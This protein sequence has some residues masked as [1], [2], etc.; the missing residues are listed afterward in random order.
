MRVT[1]AIITAASPSQARLPLQTVVDRTGSSRTALQLLLED[2]AQAG[3]EDVAVIVCPDQADRFSQAAGGLAE[4]LTFIE[5]GQPRGYGDALLRAREFAGTDP[6]LHL[7]GD[8]LYVSHTGKSCAAQLLEIAEREQ[9]SVSAVQATRENQL[10]YFGAV[11]GSPVPRRT[12]LFEVNSVLEKPTPTVAEQQLIV[13]GQRAGYYLCLFG[14][15]VLTSNVFELLAEEVDRLEVGQTANL[16]S[17]LHKLAQSQRYLAAE[18]EGE[19]YNI[20]QK[21]GLLIAQLAIALAGDEREL[22]LSELLELVAR[23]NPI[24]A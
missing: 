19:R 2:V 18:L 13:A 22:I 3:I 9:C 11:G 10:H 6:V 7:V 16:S 21:Y 17:S 20:G 15:H 24:H 12:G 4:N 5:Q 23:S 14:M 1:K 8:H